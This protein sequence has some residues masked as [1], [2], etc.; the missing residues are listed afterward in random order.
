MIKI[1]EY[2]ANSRKGHN[3]ILSGATVSHSIYLS[4]SFNMTIPSFIMARES[5]VNNDMVGVFEAIV[6]FED[7]SLVIDKLVMRVKG[8]LGFHYLEVVERLTIPCC[9][10]IDSGEYILSAKVQYQTDASDLSTLLQFYIEEVAEVQYTPIGLLEKQDFCIL[11]K[12]YS[13][14]KDL[15][16]GTDCRC[17]EIKKLYNNA[18]ITTNKVYKANPTK[19]KKDIYTYPILPATKN[20]DMSSFSIVNQDYINNK[21]L[22]IQI[23]RGVKLN[24]EFVYQRC[25]P[26]GKTD[27]FF[28]ED[29]NN[30]ITN[31]DLSL[32]KVKIGSDETLILNTKDEYEMLNVAKIRYMPRTKRGELILNSLLADEFLNIGIINKKG[33]EDEH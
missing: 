4:N 22:Y 6:S 15:E 30:W 5:H 23:P 24:N 1:A 10:L 14:T 7:D 3:T 21:K 29:E 27:F 11:S 18:V 25:I 17:G 16:D 20:I 33:F 28:D 19:Q 32:C 13:A 8:N 9:Q 31:K 26:S 2:R 12:L